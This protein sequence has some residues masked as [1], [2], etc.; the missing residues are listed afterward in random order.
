[1]AW[2]AWVAP[3][4]LFLLDYA[5]CTMY[6]A[7]RKLRPGWRYRRQ[8][9]RAWGGNMRCWSR[10]LHR[11]IIQ[12]V[13]HF[14]EKCGDYSFHWIM[15][16]CRFK[17]RGMTSTACL[18]RPFTRS[19]KRLDSRISYWRRSLQLWQTGEKGSLHL[20]WSGRAGTLTW[21]IHKYRKLSWMRSS[22]PTT[23]IHLPS[24]WSPES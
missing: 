16:T 2:A 14:N 10:D 12:M 5:W 9:W 11:Y 22:Q 19:S 23:L 21:R 3:P 13:A 6:N 1:M 8:C 18:L 24:L 17:R 15:N 20:Q 4:A 7:Y